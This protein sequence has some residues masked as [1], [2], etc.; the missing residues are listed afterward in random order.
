MRKLHKII[1]ATLVATLFGTSLCVL[2]DEAMFGTAEP[3]HKVS[4][5]YTPAWFGWRSD[6]QLMWT[7]VGDEWFH[8][9]EDGERLYQQTFDWVGPFSEGLAPVR[10]NG[11]EFHIRMDG[12]HAY[13]A[14]YDAVGPFNVGYAP[15]VQDGNWFHIKTDGT[16]AYARNFKLVTS[17][18]E[19]GRAFA[20]ERSKI[21]IRINMKG[22][23]AK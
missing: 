12:S 17:V 7:R 9:H 16:R 8:T 23:R 10:K 15:A 18:Y 11:R 5:T 21:R 19:T 2:A 22:E 3:M 1:M 13:E 14:T 20:V 4:E 6:G